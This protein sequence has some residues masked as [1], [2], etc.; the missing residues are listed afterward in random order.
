MLVRDRAGKPGGCKRELAEP[1][2]G[3]LLVDIYFPSPCSCFHPCSELSPFTSYQ[4]AVWGGVGRCE[5]FCLQF[6]LAQVQDFFY[7]SFTNMMVGHAH[8]KPKLL[9]AHLQ[10]GCD[11]TLHACEECH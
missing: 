11:I 4:E 3:S 1:A 6:L 5:S 9:F 8:N 2:E 10:N 7:N